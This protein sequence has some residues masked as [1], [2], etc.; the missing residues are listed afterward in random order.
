MRCVSET[1]IVLTARVIIY[2]SG[3]TMDAKT[4]AKTT[5]KPVD[6]AVAGSSK[7]DLKRKHQEHQKQELEENDENTGP[8]PI[9]KLE[10]NCC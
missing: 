10:V 1:A 4:V 9:V 5:N 6:T 3:S 2:L 7:P 8:I